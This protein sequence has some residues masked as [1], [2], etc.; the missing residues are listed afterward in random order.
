MKNKRKALITGGTGFVGSHLT[1]RLVKDGWDVHVITRSKSKLFLFEEVKNKITVHVHDGSMDGMLKIVENSKPSIVF[2]LAS[3]FLAQHKPNDIGELIS[4][5]ITFGTQL[6]EAMVHHNVDKL[7][8][9][10]T[11]WQHYHNDQYNPA[12]LYAATKQAFESIITYYLESSPLQVITL[13]LYDT[14]GPNDNREKLFS[15]LRKVEQEK[16]TLR[17]SPGQQLIDL[18]YIDDVV[19]A[20][21]LSAKRLEEGKVDKNYEEFAVSSG[22]PIQLK[23]LVEIYTRTM[24]KSLKINWGGRPYRQREVMLPWNKGKRL[25]GWSPKIRI[26]E[27]IRKMEKV[28][29]ENQHGGD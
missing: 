5:N 25:P 21:R 27:G 4:S 10:G 8:N 16:E 23:H 18:V 20:F 3:L 28:N 19:E 11:S 17:M 12:C 9:T 24:K 13:K 6:L 7:V 2:H 1:Y 22:R 14:Y 26:E 29:T 15:L